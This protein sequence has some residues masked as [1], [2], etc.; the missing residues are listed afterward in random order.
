[1]RFF[2]DSR[3]RLVLEGWAVVLGFALLVLPAHMLGD[4]LAQESSF[5]VGA[6]W[7][8]LLGRTARFH[9]FLASLAIALAA[10]WHREKSLMRAA[11][12]VA[13]I[14][15]G[16]D[17]G[18]TIQVAAAV[19]S[20]DKP[21]AA[22]PPS[23][24]VL[25]ANLLMINKKTEGIVAEVQASGADLILFQEY[26]DHWHAA[27]HPV[28]KETHPHAEWVTRD[29]SFGIAMYSKHP[30]V[31]PARSD[32]A[33]GGGGVPQQRAV[34][35]VGGRRVAV[36]NIHLLP[37]RTWQYT[38]EFRR[39]FRDLLA[40]I[41]KEKDPVLL[42][43]DFNF[44]EATLQAQALG[45]LGLRDAWD[46]AGSGYGATWPVVSALRYLPGIRLDHVYAGPGLGVLECRTGTGAGSDHR[47]LSARLRV[48]AVGSGLSMQH[49]KK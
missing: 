20:I 40:S 8:V 38:V 39:Q 42:S 25:S 47:P 3:F 44:T 17:L 5:A 1:M 43:G 24:Q 28:L 15:G 49:F 29:D 22:A 31:E 14:S 35:E 33:L 21:G 32:H 45:A 41:G 36:Y 9:A 13:L 12:A 16:L 30:F 4:D 6:S 11:A 37:P 2:K 19:A 10:G 34:I 27:L 26:T 7:Y 46:V 48:V 23:L 18:R